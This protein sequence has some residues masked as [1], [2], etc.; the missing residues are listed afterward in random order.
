M[1]TAQ[2]AFDFEA[3]TAP[4]RESLVAALEAAEAELVR[5][6]ALAARATSEASRTG[7]LTEM[8]R[9][10]ALRGRAATAAARARH[11]VHQHDQDEVCA[12][13]VRAE[14]LRAGW[15]Y[16]LHAPGL[17]PRFASDADRLRFAVQWRIAAFEVTELGDRHWHRGY[18]YP[19]E[20][21]ARAAL[22]ELAAGREPA[23]PMRPLRPPAGRSRKRNSS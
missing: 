5:V 18:V 10:D 15:L 9:V 3:S 4:V 11:R 21:E 22:A 13:Y 8:R 12:P 6:D 1:E 14:A 19:A 2:L 7:D 23:P 16:R 17:E 20:S